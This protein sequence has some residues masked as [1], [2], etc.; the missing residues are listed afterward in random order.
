RRGPQARGGCRG[1]PRVEGG[2]RMTD[3]RS[4]GGMRY[5]GDHHVPG[6]WHLRLVRSTVPSARVTTVDTSAVGDGVVVLTPQDAAGYGTYGCQIDDQRILAAEPRFVGDPVAA[7]VAPT[8][9]AARRA[10]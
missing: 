6:E 1:T 9:D 3:P 10:A 7:V 8:P 2:G 5:V 4:T